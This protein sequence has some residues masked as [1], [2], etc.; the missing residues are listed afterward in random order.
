LTQV[1]LAVRAGTTQSAVSMYERRRKVPMLD[2]AQRLVQ[3]A[4]ADLA[5]VGTVVWEVH[6]LPGLGKFFCPDRLW[7]VEVPG[8]FDTVRMPDVVGGT[9]RGEWDLRDRLQR[10]GLY[11]NLLV[12]G[13]HRMIARWVDGALLVDLWS[14]IDVPEQI[15]TAWE[16]AVAAASAGRAYAVFDHDA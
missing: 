3:A 16:P 11:E 13:T 7:R 14:E 9:G 4:G 6:Y 1:E 2:V 5:L 10:R 8:C 12:E 15:R